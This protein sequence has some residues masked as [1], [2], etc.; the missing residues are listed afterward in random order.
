MTSSV[1]SMCR[2]PSVPDSPMSG[3]R[4]PKAK[5]CSKTPTVSPGSMAACRASSAS[6]RQTRSCE[7]LLHWRRSPQHQRHGRRHAPRTRARGRRKGG[8]AGED[9]RPAEYVQRIYESERNSRPVLAL[10]RSPFYDDLLLTIHDFHFA[11]WKITLL[12]REEPIFRS[13]NTRGS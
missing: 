7:P 1:M 3:R 5:L 2:W 9:Q 13:A 4:V 11:M 10:E 8:A 6:S 12:D